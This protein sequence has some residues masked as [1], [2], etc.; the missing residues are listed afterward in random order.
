MKFDEYTEHCIA[1]NV[2]TQLL[3]I[4]V[5]IRSDTF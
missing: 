4:D 1:M 3:K 5:L 2:N